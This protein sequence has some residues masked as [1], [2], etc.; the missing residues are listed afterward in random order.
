M[1][2]PE[3]FLWVYD[4]PTRGLALVRGRNVKTV[5]ELAGAV[6]SSRWSTSGKG[7]VIPGPAVADVV[8]IAEHENIPVRCKRVG[9]GR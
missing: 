2:A 5:L 4:D 7:Y 6:D 1:P 9:D 3:S 8:A